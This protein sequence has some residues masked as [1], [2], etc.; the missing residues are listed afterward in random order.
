MS[1]LLDALALELEKR[2][3]YDAKKKL[4][5]ALTKVVASSLLLI[6]LA[7][8]TGY[9]LVLAAIPLFAAMFLYGLFSTGRD[10]GLINRETVLFALH[11]FILANAGFDVTG[12]FDQFAKMKEYAGSYIFRKI[13]SYF[14]FIGM[15]LREAINEVLQEEKRL[16]VG[17]KSFLTSVYN[18]MTT[19]I[20]T[21]SI[22]SMIIQQEVVESEK[23][24]DAFED[25]I[26]TFLSGLM[27]F[28]IMVPLLMVLLGGV[29]NMPFIEYLFLNLGL[30]IGIGLILLFSENKF[31]Y[32][33]E[34][35]LFVHKAFGIQLLLAI[36]STLLGYY[37]IG[38]YAF[39][40]GALVFFVVG[41]LMTGNY[42]KLR[43]DTYAYLPVFLADLGGRISIGQT[44]TEA[45]IS[46][47]L[48]LSGR[49]SK[50]LK[51][52]L[53]NLVNVGEI[54]RRAEFDRIFIYRIYKKL[55]SDLQKGIYGYEALLNIRTIIAM[56][57]S[58]YNRVRGTLSM[59]SLLMAV[60]LAFSTLFVDLMAF[61]GEK[62]SESMLE[63]HKAESITGGMQGILSL[64]SFLKAKPWVIDV[65]FIFAAMLLY[66]FGIFISSISDGTRH[67]NAQ[68][69]IYVISSVILMFL[70]H[71]VV[72][73]ALFFIY[74]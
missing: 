62:I 11:G 18:G 42:I 27:P 45:I 43:R 14:Y 55:I 73:P 50:V 32:Y 26:N 25:S 35:I 56:M 17:F 59:N 47:P 40:I 8:V 66:L 38:S 44:F 60:S 61:L 22:F 72:A 68:A 4:K 37:T 6:I 52:S 13:M 28:V 46:M 48:S 39:L 58:V 65:Y 31:L 69:L 41:Y 29:A 30:A 57:S 15:D 71:S 33:P 10:Y 64:L 19:G 54:P 53:G 3:V 20:D 24:I 49:F 67:G 74:R 5:S 12:I 23:S 21:R 51:Y 2:G 36:A 63:I 7:V 70:M 34:Q 9:Y 16:G 1:R